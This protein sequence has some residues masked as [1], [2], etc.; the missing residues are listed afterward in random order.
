M[1]VLCSQPSKR[2]RAANAEVVNELLG[3]RGQKNVHQPWP[4]GP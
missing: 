2:V 1:D 3:W 4:L